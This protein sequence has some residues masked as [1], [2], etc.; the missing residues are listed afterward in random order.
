MKSVQS[1][2]E[3]ISHQFDSISNRVETLHHRFC[4]AEKRMKRFST[5]L[6]QLRQTRRIRN[7]MQYCCVQGNFPEFLKQCS[8][9][10]RTVFW[11]W[12]ANPSKKS[13]VQSHLILM[14][15]PVKGEGK[16]TIRIRRDSSV[17]PSEFDE[18]LSC[19]SIGSPFESVKT[20][21]SQSF[22]T[23]AYIICVE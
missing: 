7:G 2:K 16:L 13:H 5:L 14:K 12:E 23:E 6:L 4:Q 11:N 3:N 20:K 9:E 22:A 8:T 15:H 17:S 19:I 21:S 10:K 18:V 1:F